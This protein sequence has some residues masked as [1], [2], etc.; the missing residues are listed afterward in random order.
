MNSS[1][2]AKLAATNIRKNAKNYLPYILTCLITIMMFYMM[3]FLA[4]NSALGSMAGGGS[5]SII[6]SLG[7]I[8]IGIFA[9]IFLFYTNSFLIKRRKKEIGLYNILGME[10]KHIAKVLA[11]ENL[12]VAIISLTLGLSFGILLSKLMVLTLGKLLNF[13]I[14]FGF[15]ISEFALLTTLILFVV[16]FL[17]LLLSNLRQIHLANPIE[18]LRGKQVGEKEPKT[19]WILALIGLAC[20][21]G[22]Y[23]ISVTTKSP[24]QALGLFFV[25]VILVIIGT[26]CV[27][28]AGSI[29]IL[30]ILRKNK[31]YYY[32]ANH[33]ISVSGMIYRMKQ[34]AVGLANICILSTMVLVMISSTVSLYI[35][36]EDTLRSMYPKNIAVSGYSISEEEARELTDVINEI[37]NSH[38]VAQKDVISYRYMSQGVKKQGNQF[39]WNDSYVYGETTLYLIPLSDYNKLLGETNTL[40]SDEVLVK[41]SNYTKSR[42]TDETI[43]IG[44]ENFHIKEMT[45]VSKK[46]IYYKQD[47]IDIYYIILPDIDTFEKISKEL[48]NIKGDN[49]RIHFYYGFDIDAPKEK[50]LEIYESIQELRAQED[51]E[52]YQK[53]YVRSVEDARDEFF[54]VYGGLFFLGLFLGTLFLMA[55]VLI[56]Y[57][58]QISEGND[59]RE[60]FEIMQKVGMSQEEVKKTIHSQVLMVFFLPIVAAAIH[61]AF[62]FNVITKLLAVLGLTNVALFTTCTLVTLGVF[63]IFYAVV[64]GLT[65]RTYYRIVKH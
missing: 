53:F 15:E 32:K 18:L 9:V 52:L 48:D 1:L 39:L 27:F 60:R 65:A 62:A 33:F 54:F 23:Y 24:L 45:E 38:Q 11:F 16:I 61:I 35:G 42:F 46:D 30:K 19:K 31:R 29:A 3:C 17:L 13:K 10:K 50:Q 25:A 56:M 20:L 26:Y 2:Y 58:K 40:K 21:S 55:T 64:Y 12:Y 22:G 34:N 36:F 51:V 43:V 37:T 8:V 7:T 59:D 4:N 14:A 47:M 49:N 44:K 28:T 41:Y 6:L 63:I 5:L 57:Y